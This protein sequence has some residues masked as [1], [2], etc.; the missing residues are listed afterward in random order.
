MITMAPTSQIKL[1]IVYLLRG[2]LTP[3]WLALLDDLHDRAGLRIDDDALFVDDGIGITGI[4]SDRHQDDLLR[5]RFADDD[6]LFYH[7]RVLNRLLLN[8]GDNTFR[9]RVYC[10]TG[11][12]ADRATD[13]SADR[14]T[15]DRARDGTTCCTGDG[16][17]GVFRKSGATQC[18]GE[19]G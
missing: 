2:G 11:D 5:N 12:R 8:I 14:P 10:R 16:A 9:R 1:F 3:R 18:Q 19:N 7:H 15:N 6:R 4:F 13:G 17:V